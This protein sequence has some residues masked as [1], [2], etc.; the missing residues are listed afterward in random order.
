M[1]LMS[2]KARLDVLRG[3]PQHYNTIIHIYY[4]YEMICALDLAQSTMKPTNKKKPFGFLKY[5]SH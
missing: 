1:A 4:P 3:I 2:V 5:Y